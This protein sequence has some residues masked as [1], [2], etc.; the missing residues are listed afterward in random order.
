M[1]NRWRYDG[2]VDGLAQALARSKTFLDAC[3]SGNHDLVREFLLKTADD[4]YAMGFEDGTKH[5]SPPVPFQ[6]LSHLEEVSTMLIA[7]GRSREEFN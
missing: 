2:R 1:H 6:D 7:T 5:A 3:M 4:L